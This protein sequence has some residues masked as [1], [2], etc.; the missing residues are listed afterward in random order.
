MTGHRPRLLRVGYEGHSLDVF[1]PEAAL[2]PSPTHIRIDRQ[3][4][5]VAVHGQGSWDVSVETPAQLSTPLLKENTQY[6]VYLDGPGKAVL[7]LRPAPILAGLRRQRGATAHYVVNFGSGVGDTEW[8]WTTEKGEIGLQLEVFPTKLDYRKDFEAIKEDLNKL[9]R[10]LLPR[11]RAATGLRFEVDAALQASELEWAE[12]LRRN[13]D[14]LRGGMEQLLPRLRQRHRSTHILVSSERLR[15][16][17]PLTRRAY[18]QVA[19]RS[20]T[21]IA[22]RPQLSEATALNGHLRWEIDRFGAAAQAIQESDWVSQ[23]PRDVQELISAA[24]EEATTWHTRVEN[25]PAV[26]LLPHMQTRLRDP[27]YAQCIRS[28]RQLR[29]GLSESDSPQ[30]LGIKDLAL[31]Y[32][33]WVFIAFVARVAVRF[34]QVTAASPSMVQELSGQVVLR[35]GMESRIELGR[36]DGAVVQCTYNQ[37]FVGLPTTNQRPDI[38]VTLPDGL[39]HFVIDAKYRLARSPRYLER[40]G[41]V[42]PE[43]DDINV[44]HRYRDAI[45]EPKTGERLVVG[46]LIA[47]PGDPDEYRDHHFHRSW[48]TSG[49]AGVPM[50]PTKLALL[51]DVLDELFYQLDPT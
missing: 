34:P 12:N 23:L 48:E 44:L 14:S 11:F 35:R 19:K 5:R 10:A 2:G 30:L 41:A 18:G 37:T 20:K 42:G 24:S 4:A 27:L 43:E 33:Y 8:R 46:G 1:G 40:Y 3:V 7:E 38:V 32:E 29:L 22:R 9:S 26:P 13:F 39:G 16:A 25:I 50:L 36:D 51:D 17:M 31:L 15:R 45:V 21:M 6:D 49:V 28:L 47:F